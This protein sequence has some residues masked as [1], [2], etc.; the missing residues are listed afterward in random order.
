M[1]EALLNYR[2]K[3]EQKSRGVRINRLLFDVSDDRIVVSGEVSTY[4]EI[5]LI[6]V[7]AS[8]LSEGPQILSNLSVVPCVIAQLPREPSSDEA[9]TELHRPR[10]SGN[11]AFALG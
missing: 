6:Q 9:R 3:C 4:Y 10:S 1:D 5:Q 8:S 11:H 2:L 7:Y